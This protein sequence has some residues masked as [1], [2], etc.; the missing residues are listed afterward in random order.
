MIILAQKYTVDRPILECDILRWAPQTLEK[1]NGE[2]NQFYFD[3]LKE[4]SAMS[5]KKSYLELEVEVIDKAD[6]HYD[7]ADGGH[8]RLVKLGHIALVS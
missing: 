8:L 6:G 4:G 1:R 5:L 7:C 2:N 3:I